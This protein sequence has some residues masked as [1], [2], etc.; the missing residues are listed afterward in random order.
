MARNKRTLKEINEEIAKLQAEADSLRE[1]EKAEVVARIKEAVVFYGITAADIGFSASGGK[2]R[3]A[4]GGV[5]STA[6]TATRMK[7]K[8]GAGRTWSGHGRKPQWFIDAMNSGKT[9]AD[10]RA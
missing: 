1:A 6:G 3:K 9:E 8:D 2:G 10:L 5:K 7:Y 4:K